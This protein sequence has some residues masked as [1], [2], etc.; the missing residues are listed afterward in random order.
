V[1][2]KLTY[3]KGIKWLASEG[4]TSAFNEIKPIDFINF[5]LSY[6]IKVLDRI[7]FGGGKV[8]CPAVD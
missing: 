3:H 4:N 8:G 2:A 5:A 7:R 1:S 6:R